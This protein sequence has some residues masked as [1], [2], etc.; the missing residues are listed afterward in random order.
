VG[1]EGDPIRSRISQ[2]CELEK[3]VGVSPVAVCA[4]DE[5]IVCRL[6]GRSELTLRDDRLGGGS[7]LRLLGRRGG[8]SLRLG[9]FLGLLI[10]LSIIRRASTA[11][12]VLKATLELLAYKREPMSVWLRINLRNLRE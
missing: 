11:L 3:A 4:R 5:E 1:S 12:E 2:V 6:P 10:G 7:G 8:G 9:G